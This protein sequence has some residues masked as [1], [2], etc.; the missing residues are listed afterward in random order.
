MLH[1]HVTV[2]LSLPGCRGKI[3]DESFSSPKR[4]L[5]RAIPEG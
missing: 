3:A 2:I 5:E 1:R 4:P